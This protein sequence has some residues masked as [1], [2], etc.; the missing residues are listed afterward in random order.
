MASG[1]FRGIRH[2]SLWTWTLCNGGIKHFYKRRNYNSER[3]EPRIK[4]LGPGWR[5][6]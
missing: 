1:E 5:N 3:D 4:N 2:T 6:G